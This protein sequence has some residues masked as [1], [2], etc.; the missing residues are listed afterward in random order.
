MQNEFDLGDIDTSAL[1]AQSGDDL[2]PLE[3]KWPTTLAEMVDVLVARN[4]AKGMTEDAAIIEAQ[5]VIIVIGQY[6]GARQI[7][8]PRGDSLKEALIARQIYLLHRGNNT[9]ELA[10]RF[11]FSVRWV[12]RIYAEQRRIQIRRRQGQLFNQEGEGK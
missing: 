11:G 4:R 10:D 3:D 6:C 7:Y 9:E 2:G 8:L 5:E 12:Q 1:M